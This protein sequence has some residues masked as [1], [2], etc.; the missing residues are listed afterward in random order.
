MKEVTCELARQDIANDDKW[1][2]HASGCPDCHELLTVSRWMKDLAE[3]SATMRDLPE[4]GF[5]LFK[6]RIQERQLAADRAA[7]PVLAMIIVAGILLAAMVGL[8][9]RTET[10]LATVLIEAVGMLFSYAGI[11]IIAAVIVAAVCALT[12]QLGA[13]TRG[14]DHVSRKS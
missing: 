5:L 13:M 12:A 4:A 8:A 7:L 6:G 3:T 9:V 11:M 1:R 2:Q 10:R 14:S